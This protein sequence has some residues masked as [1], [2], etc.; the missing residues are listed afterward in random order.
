V[1]ILTGFWNL[2]VSGRMSPGGMDGG[3]GT[4]LIVKMVFVVLSGLG[5]GLHTF[6]KR[7]VFKAVWGSV[8]LI[9]ALAALL[10]GVSM[11]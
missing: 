4:T 6:A 7:P 8:G 1:L 9:G 3:Y 5:A 2:Q 11:G 10:L